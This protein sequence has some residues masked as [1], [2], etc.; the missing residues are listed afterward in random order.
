MSKI[1]VYE[2]IL[3]TYNNILRYEIATDEFDAHEQAKKHFVSI[4]SDDLQ[5]HM[6]GYNRTGYALEPS[7]AY[8]VC[9][10]RTWNRSIR[11]KMYKIYV[12]WKNNEIEAVDEFE[13]RDEA[14]RMLSE[15]KMAYRNSYRRIWVEKNE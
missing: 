9:Y 14:E 7:L 13:G 5:I 15:Y 4:Y 11:K 1:P 8:E 6:G 3:E 10:D 2:L 12:Q